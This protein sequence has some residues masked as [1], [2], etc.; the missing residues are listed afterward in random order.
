MTDAINAT[1]NLMEAPADKI[2]IRTSYNVSGVSFSPK[3]IAT[4][5]QKHIPEFTISYKSDSRQNIADS[6]PQSIDDTVAR[7]DW[8]WQP[9]F[10]LQRLTK[11][12]LDN[13]K[14]SL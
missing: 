9:D 10:N 6:W 11:E 1:I 8:G 7:N 5:I 2:S 13:L 3:E 4:E 14:L 12:M